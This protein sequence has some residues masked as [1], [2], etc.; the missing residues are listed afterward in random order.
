[1]PDPLASASPHA[2]STIE[3][4]RGLGTDPGLGLSEGEARDRLEQ[5]GPNTIEGRRAPP[6]AAIALRQFTDPLVLLLAAATAVSLAI[7]EGVEA[8]AI[9]AIVVLNAVLGFSQELGAERAILALRCSL[10]LHASA[11]RAGSERELPAEDLVPG[12]LMVLREGERVPADGRLASAEALAVDESLLTGESIPAEKSLDPVP[13]QTP[14]ADRSPIVYSGT[15]VTRGHGTAIVVATGARAEVGQLAQLTAGAKSPPTPL[16]LRLGGLTRLMVLAGLLITALLAGMRLLQGADASEAFLLG[17][18]V[19]VAAVPEGLAA[20]TTIALALGARRM[21]AR[22]A[23]VRRLPAVETLGSAT[24]VA[25]DK[26]GTLTEN[27]LRLRALAAAGS[28]SEAEVLEAAVLASAAH[29]LE[30]EVEGRA[31]GDPVDV[32]LLAGSVARGVSPRKLRAGR[33]PV[34]EL[35]FDPERK[36]VTVAYREEGLVRAYMKGAPEVVLACSEASVEERREIEALAERWASQGLRVLAVA[37]RT[38]DPAAAEDPQQLERGLQLL[39]LVALQDPLREGAAAAVRG[40][41]EA[42]VRVQIVTGDHPATAVAVA[43]ELGMPEDSVSARVTPKDKLRLVE[44]MQGEGEVVAVTGDGINDAP[45]LR[46]A[47]VGV[48]MGRSGTEAAREASDIVL[49]DD[50]FSTIVAAIHEGRAIT[51][52]VRKFVAFLL[53]AN[54]GEVLLFTTAVLAGLS[55]PMTVVQVLTVNVLTDGLPAVALAADP[56]APDV[57]RRAPERRD[58]LF[59]TWS[60]GALALVGLLVGSASVGAFLV[61]LDLDREAAQTMAFATVA[62]A[63]LIFVFAVRSPLRP[64][65]GEPA[66]PALLGSIAGSVALLALAVYLPPLHD[67]FGTVGLTAGQLA[68]VCGFAV[69]P[70]AVVEVAKSSLRRYAPAWAGAALR[71]GRGTS[72]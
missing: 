23:I 3:V 59:G 57:M 34:A 10:V 2:A 35:P 71:P 8:A 41:R 20:T 11:I 6:Y 48:A 69:L 21:A 27:E 70:F 67:A 38:L 68:I 62:L 61:A 33:A 46:Q 39:G 25:S 9:G 19:A 7:G 28:H 32:A 1:M 66:N 24:V 13:A 29:L 65:W 56:P 63:E 58:R 44:S 49:T 40:A 53:S 18:S 12:D 36:R 60:W 54:L 55:V 43:R 72:G 51:D 22:G 37:S 26:T 5:F 42:G 52:N 50:D 31:V 14:L 47:H 45:A 4:A 17:A 64:F 16:Q 15:G 30:D